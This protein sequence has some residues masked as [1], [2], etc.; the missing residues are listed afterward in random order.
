MGTLQARRAA[1]GKGNASIFAHLSRPGER[2]G[3]EKSAFFHPFVRGGRVAGGL[4]MVRVL[5]AVFGV[6]YLSGVSS[7]G[8]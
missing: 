8:G 2:P 1:K 3:V 4:K 5:A 6:V 7:V